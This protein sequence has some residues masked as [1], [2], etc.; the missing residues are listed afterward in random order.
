[1]QPGT[2]L[3]H[4]EILSALGKGGMG[5]VWKARDTK[6]GREVAIKTLPPEFAEDTERLGRFEREAKLLASLNHPNIAAIY[7]LEEH[8]GSRF[9]VLELVEGNT[10]VDRLDGRTG[11]A[12]GPQAGHRPPGAIPV[13]K[14]LELAVQITEALEAAHEK[15]IVHRDLK[16]A[17]VKV[18]PEGRVKVLDFGLAKAFAADAGGASLSHSPTLSL[19]AT[20][21]GVI[22]GTAAYM[23]PEQAKGRDVDKRTDI[24]SFG[25]VLYEMLTGRSPFRGED[26]AD[27]LAFVLT[28]DVKWEDLPAD[29]PET[30]RH[31]LKRC[32]ERDPRQR[33]RDIGDAR[34]DIREALSVTETAMPGARTRTVQRGK[35]QPYVTVGACLVTAIVTAGA[36]TLWL[37][38]EPL[39]AERFYVSPQGTD[40]VLGVNE[41]TAVISPDGQRV[42]YVTNGN[43]RRLHVRSFSRLEQDTLAGL[44]DPRH[45]FFSPDGEW[46]AFLDG[47]VLRKVNVAGGPAETIVDIGATALYGAVWSEDDRIIIGT[48]DLATGLLRVSAQGGELEVLTTPDNG[49][50]EVEHS[51][52]ALL[53]GGTGVLF[54]V[55]RAVGEIETAQV[56]VLD[57]DTRTYQV[58]VRGATDAQYVPTGHLVYGSEGELQAVAFDPERRETLGDARTVLDQM[59]ISSAGHTLFSIG[60]DGSAVYVAGI[61]EDPDQRRI[62]WVDREGREESTGIPPAAYNHVRLSPDGTRAALDNRS[63]AG[64]VLIW[65]FL[66]Q[67]LDRLTVTPNTVD[68]QPVWSADGNRIVFSSNRDGGTINLFA[69]AADG[70]GTTEKWTDTSNPTYPTAFLP[71]GSGLLYWENTSEG[72]PDVHLLEWD[73]QPDDGRRSRSLIATTF[74]DRNAEV[75]PNGRW[76]AYQSNQRGEEQIF[77]LPFP[78]V[79]SSAPRQ[80]TNAGGT[81]PMWSPAGDELF[82]IGGPGR[83]MTLPVDTGETFSSG[84]PTE[85]FQ[86]PY[87]TLLLSRLYDY[88][89]ERDQFLMIREGRSDDDAWTTPQLVLVRN[90]FEELRELVPLD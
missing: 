5:E 59:V 56:A 28:Q 48:N 26:L 76:L 54:T 64:D 86:G 15:G 10:L 62:V 61:P 71:D 68:R 85:V 43:P 46:I 57:L 58:I 67:T 29:A 35:W 55:F 25:C 23:S 65:S 41:R 12:G 11:S 27:T 70:T 18:D 83:M 37:R 36:T 72:G 90:W 32:L 42:A 19:E 14:A 49:A 53:P 17:N 73:G 51:H 20:R 44:G 75:S 40:L 33:L 47:S 4:Y 88:S 50:G 34:A 38:P 30:V 84:T 31:L 63:E 8:E 79:E 13:R 82:Y 45:P 6:L 69:H 66:R 9:L 89:V 74:V 3:A 1:M 60:A 80:V 7:G 52:P 78:E 22:L 2:R 39:R 16:P 87:F 81:R 24:W 77:V 21:Q